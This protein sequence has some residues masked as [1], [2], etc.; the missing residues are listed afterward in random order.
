MEA[1]RLTV[2]KTGGAF[3]DLGV[4]TT[5]MTIRKASDAGFA[6]DASIIG[7]VAAQVEFSRIST[8]SGESDE[9]AIGLTSNCDYDPSAVA[10]V[11]SV[12]GG[13]STNLGD[14]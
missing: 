8:D 2:G 1:A 4:T 5:Q 6:S 11:T 3:N 13:C 7:E 12:S 14:S 10:P 9:S